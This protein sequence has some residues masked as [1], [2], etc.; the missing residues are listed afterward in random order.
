M[1]F[2]V[3]SEYEYSSTSSIA[4]HCAP[5]EAK[6]CAMRSIGVAAGGA[7]Q[8]EQSVDTRQEDIS[9]HNAAKHGRATAGAKMGLEEDD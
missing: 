4:N 1:D 6:D 7:G 8:N 9:R 3:L 2:G 5:A